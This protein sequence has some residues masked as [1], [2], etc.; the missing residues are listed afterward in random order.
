MVNASLQ[1]DYRAIITAKLRVRGGVLPLKL[2]SDHRGKRTY[3]CS[4]GHP[5]LAELVER[6]DDELWTCRV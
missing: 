3:F 4:E 1:V 6:A 5:A 2:R